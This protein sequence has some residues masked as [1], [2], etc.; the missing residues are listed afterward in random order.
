MAEAALR[1]GHMVYSGYGKSPTSFG[2][3]IRFDVSDKV[4]VREVFHKINPEVVVHSAAMTDVDKCETDKKL[5]WKINVAGTENVAE[6]TEKTKAFLI[7]VS[8]DYVFN[9]KKGRYDENDT[10]DPIN[11]Y[12]VTKLEAERL[13]QVLIEEHCIVRASVIFGSTPAAGKTNFA[14]WLLNKLKRREQAN[15]VTD[16][17]NSPTLNSNMAEMT[18]EILEQKLEGVFHI[19]GA[20]RINRYDFATLLAQTFRLDSNLIQAVTSE[21][22]SWPAF[23]PRDSSLS[24]TKARRLLKNKPIKINQ[25]LLRMRKDIDSLH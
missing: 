13:V 16:Q 12:G 7:F 6:A 11:Y 15:I 1:K 4:Q 25:A 20:T 14:L 23:R 8:T 22:F 18:L 10:P 5:A 21:Y 9:G 3:P 2:T 19:S 24:T 17:W